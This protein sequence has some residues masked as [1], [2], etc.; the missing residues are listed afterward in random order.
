MKVYN[1][2]TRVKEE[3]TPLVAGQVS[4]YVCGVTPYDYSHIG[5]ARS[6]IVFDVIRRYLTS[7]GFR[8]R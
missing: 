5:H 1:T 4:M 3:F 7:R 2:M 6:A 8:V